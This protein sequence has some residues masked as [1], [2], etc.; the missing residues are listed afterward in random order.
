MNL[1]NA[2]LNVSLKIEKIALDDERYSFRMCELGLM[3]KTKVRVVKKSAFGGRVLAKG[4]V[5][6]AVDKIT[7][8]KVEVSLA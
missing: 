3:P 7:A 6:L 1:E 2:P 5:R 8:Q 4:T